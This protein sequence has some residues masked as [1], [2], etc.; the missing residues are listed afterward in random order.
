MIFRI[1]MKTPDAVEYGIKSALEYEDMDEYEAEAREDELKELC[2]KWFEF[3]ECV[4]IEINTEEGT[5]KVLETR[6]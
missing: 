1:S 2:E 6:R 4:T 5:A 3:G